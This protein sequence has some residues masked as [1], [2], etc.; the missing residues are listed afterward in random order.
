M[1]DKTFN[2]FDTH[3]HLDF[4]EFSTSLSKV[5]NSNIDKILIPGVHKS[6]WPKII[7]IT[8]NSNKLLAALGIHPLE[9]SQQQDLQVLETLISK[10]TI[11]AVGELGLDY[12]HKFHN[13]RIQTSFFIPQL[14]IADK[15]KLPVILHVRKAHNEV[16]KILSKFDNLRG[17]VHSFSGS[18]EEAKR[19]LKQGFILGIGTSITYPRSKKIFEV[20][21][22]LPLSSFVLETDA[23][24][25]KINNQPDG[26]N[27]PEN[28]L[29]IAKEVARLKN[30][31]KE[32]FFTEML[33]Q[34]NKQS[35]EILKVKK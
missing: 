30:I 17:I 1:K 4:P 22:E 15:H 27:Y 31:D 6:N 12:Y 13:K 29:I 2:L 32:Y 7:D 21:E 19:Y 35:Y 25:M 5:L 16:L 34:L 26:L 14:E 33:N 9:A 24:C 10:H 11:V 28:L 23:P 3:C 20:V 8:Q 18:L